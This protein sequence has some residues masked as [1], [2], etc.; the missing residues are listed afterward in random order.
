MIAIGLSLCYIANIWNIGA[1]GQ[2]IDRRG[3]RQL[4]CGAH[5]RHRGRPLGAAG[6]VAARRARR[7]AL[8]G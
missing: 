5:Q 1:E 3:V 2:F 7:R 4:A 8:R 6:D